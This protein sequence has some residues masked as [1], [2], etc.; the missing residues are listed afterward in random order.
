MNRIVLVLVALTGVT[1]A[2]AQEHFPTPDAAARALQKATASGKA[3]R[4]LAV[5]GPDAQD[6]VSSG[7][8]VADAAAL[9]RYATAAAARTRIEQLADGKAAV[10]HIGHDDWPFPIPLAHDDAGWRFDTAEGKDELVNRR[11]GRNE[12]TAIEVCR[13]YVDAQHE[14]AQ[15]FKEYAQRVRST[16][17]KHDGLYWETTDH[18]PSPLGPLIASA[19]GEGY[20]VREGD[21]APQP[22]HG[23]FFRILTKQGASAPGGARDY[24]KDG[25]MVDGFALLAWPAEYG[26]GGV[27]TFLVGP[28]DVVFQK[29]LGAGTAEA[30]KAITAYDPDASWMPTR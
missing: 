5:L 19:S 4:V 15:R 10:V 26:S 6:I 2:G 28:Q 9:K 30:A 18:D 23:Y 13:A 24:V 1:V 12:L 25:H 27:M 8:P 20:Q 29:D 22:Y 17:G 16:P 21:Q 7:D 14:F 11:V 3:D